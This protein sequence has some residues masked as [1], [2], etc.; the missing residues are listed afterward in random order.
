M[1]IA[2]SH[3]G[4]TMYTSAYPSE[5]VLVGTREGIVTIQRNAGGSG[6]HVAQRALTDRHIHAIIAEPTSGTL[7]AGAH[8]GGLFAS[9]DGG[10]T[11]VER[12]SGLNENDIY[13]LA[14]ATVDGTTRIY[15]GTEPAHLFV[16]DDLGESWRELPAL[17]SV[18]GTEKWSFPA[19]P[20]IG[21]LKHINFDPRDAKTVYASIEV[22]GLLRSNDAGETWTVI[23]GMYEDVHRTVINPAQ[24]GRIYV[25]GGD[26]VYATSD[27]GASWEHWTTRE[28]E[29]GGYP[30]VLV[31]DQNDPNLM[32]I[33]AAQCSPG[34]WRKSHFAGAR[35]SRSRDGGKTWEVLTGGLPDRLQ[36]SI[37]AMCLEQNG[38]SATILFATTAGEVYYSDDEGETWSIAVNGLAPITKG[39]HYHALTASPA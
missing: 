11:W 2:L 17:R 26:G 37:E 23:P 8:K 28:S 35:V 9:S 25:T 15:A 1:T 18:P 38:K 7:F 32:F 6:W 31:F 20:H 16:S 12:N 24:P 33:A 36:A 14:A 21:H 19:P 3:G 34:E 29:L 5:E 4:T 27:A 10:K 13:S 30:D 39:G 22:G